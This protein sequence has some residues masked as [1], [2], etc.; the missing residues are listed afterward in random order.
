MEVTVVACRWQTLHPPP[1]SGPTV[2][3]ITP[4]KAPLMWAEPAVMV[5]ALHRNNLLLGKAVKASQGLGVVDASVRM[6]GELSLPR[7]A[8][9]E[10]RLIIHTYPFSGSNQL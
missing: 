4:E 3:L 8:C 10:L 2:A 6:S 7:G 5:P 9:E 1:D